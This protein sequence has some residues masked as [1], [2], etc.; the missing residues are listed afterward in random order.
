MRS[1]GSERG[2]RSDAEPTEPGRRPGTAVRL[3]S[4]AGVFLLLLLA[5]SGVAALAGGSPTPERP[6]TWQASVAF[7]LAVLG[8]SAWAMERREGRPVAALGLPLGPGTAGW[9]LRGF[10]VGVAIMGLAAA[11]LVAGGWLA[12]RSAP[13]ALS[14]LALRTLALTAILLPAAWAE[15]LLFRGYPF[16]VLAERWG[17]GAAIS[18]TAVAFAAVHTWNPSVDALAIVNLALA[19]VVLGLAWWRTYSLWFAAGVHLGWNWTMGVALDLPVSGLVFDMPGFDATLSGPEVWTGGAFGPE[20]GL[21][22]TVAALA[23]I[24]WLARS[25]R[26]RRDVVTLALS[27]LPERK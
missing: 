13:G 19:G 4:F 16:Q 7:A 1:L 25:R 15:E 27:P 9:L 17:G 2:R 23:G 10:A 11:L 12:W 6:L 21:A 14:G 18:A 22:V 8:A 5:L 24:A 3:A 20:G 26:L